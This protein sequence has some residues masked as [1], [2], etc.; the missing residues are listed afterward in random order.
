MSA[1]PGGGGRAAAGFYLAD[2]SA[3]PERA[4][5]ELA[6]L[7]RAPELWRNWPRKG[8]NAQLDA[9]RDEISDLGQANAAKQ[10]ELAA[11]SREVELLQVERDNARDAAHAWNLERNQKEVELRRLDAMSAC[12]GCRIAR[13]AG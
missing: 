2:C 7:E 9:S 13:A 6:L 4:H 12:A 8:L 3:G 1:G 10:A 5:A 11:L